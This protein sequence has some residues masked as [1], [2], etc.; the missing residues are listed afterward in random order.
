MT[1]VRRVAFVF[2]GLSFVTLQGCATL[3]FSKGREP[4]PH[5]SRVDDHLT[6]GGQPSPEGFRQL[7]KMGVK[8]VVDLRAEHT[9]RKEREL[10]ESLGMRWVHLPI[11]PGGRPSDKQ[12]VA[13]LD[14]AQDPDRQPVFVHCQ[15]GKHRT[16]TLIAIYRIVVE[17]WP[18]ERSY[19]DARSL[20]LLR[21]STLRDFILHEA[22]QRFVRKAP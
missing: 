21:S 10:V 15:R 2:V 20:G 3:P 12:V 13:F 6:R 18:P 4:L 16:G 8:T 5:F 9:G 1:K 19:A 17:G 22:E 14:A 11:F 7:A